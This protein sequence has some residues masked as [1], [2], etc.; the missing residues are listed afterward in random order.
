MTPAPVVTPAP[1]PTTPVTAPPANPP[2][3]P[4]ITPTIELANVS[5]TPRRDTPTVPAPA[6]APS[7]PDVS[8]T[9]V[10]AAPKLTQPVPATL[11]TRAEHVARTHHTTTGTP[12][13]P[14]E[15][16][17]RMRVNTDSAQQLIAL[18]KLREQSPTTPAT[19]VN[20]TPVGVGH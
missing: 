2:T 4:V 9:P 10:D 12:I 20:G 8:V 5:P 6:P 16:A 18:M 1:V 17:V 11:L 19:P 13:T 3:A 7:T 14:G 15:L